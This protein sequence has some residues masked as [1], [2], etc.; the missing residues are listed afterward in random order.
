[1]ANIRKQGQTSSLQQTQSLI[2]LFAGLQGDNDIDLF[3]FGR[4]L[5][6]AGNRLAD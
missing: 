3:L 2:I 6:L 5:L 1:M 4:D